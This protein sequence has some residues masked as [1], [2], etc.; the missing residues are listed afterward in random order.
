[1]KLRIGTKIG[2]GFGIV[3]VLIAVNV[4]FAVSALSGIAS[5]AEIVE[6]A[7][8]RLALGNN[9]AYQ[10]QKAVV[11]IR[12]YVA[13]GDPKG[14]DRVE[15]ELK[16]AIRLENELLKIARPDKKTDVEQMIASSQ[17]YSNIILNDYMPVARAYHKEIAAGNY[18][19]A[20]E[21]KA[22]LNEIAK[23]VVPLSVEVDKTLKTVA[24]DNAKIVAD[25][26]HHTAISAQNTRT[27][28]MIVGAAALILG[29]I[30]SIVLTLMV[31]KPV[32][33]LASVTEK[34]AQGDLRAV[35]DITSS[36]ELGD[37]ANSLRTMRENLTAIVTNIARSSEQVAAASEELTASAQESAHAATQVACVITDIAQGT[38]NQV[39]ATNETTLAVEQMAAG[40]KQ[41]AVSAVGVAGMAD[42]AAEAASGGGKSVATAVA[43]MDNI[44][45][46]VNESAGVVT[47]LGERS[48]E[49]GQIVDTISGLAGQ[50][51]LLA[52]NAAIEA[53][54]AGEQG[55]G[56]AVVAE[57]VR[58]LAEQSQ[59]AAKQI[60]DLISEIQGDTDKA[61]Y[62]MSEGTRE[63]RAG[64]QI[65]NA[66]GESFKEIIGLITEVSSQ[67]REI[68]AAIQQMAAGST[69]IVSSVKDIEGICKETAG[70]TQTVSAA[71]QEQSASMQ[72][73]AASS[74]SLAKLAE[75]LQ[76]AISRFKL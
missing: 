39:R 15:A 17:K 2:L 74:H 41:I 70:Q 43:Q 40:I 23:V 32:V 68:S 73:I 48:K 66:T 72:E 30:L 51:N 50:T 4:F 11:T 27:I 29:G 75:E 67:V 14:A 7:N 47:K 38:E 20:Q 59:T 1:M 35:A 13:F 52:L 12:T 57:E 71:T 61:V 64:T 26:L 49:I 16:E 28:S 9:I 56:F 69:Q 42:K 24:D 60:A 44:E 55:R 8:E 21:H 45:K 25:N 62:S 53:A 6:S 46:T 54:R 58:K 5:N 65:V 31:K 10:Y 3:M 22:K 19:Q 37:L 33:Q 34:Y 76:G 63:V 18:V 36:D